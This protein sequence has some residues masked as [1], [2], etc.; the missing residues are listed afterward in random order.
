MIVNVKYLGMLVDQTGKTEEKIVFDNKS[1]ADLDSVLQGK[2]PILKELPYN[3]VVNHE[4][5]SS[6]L[7]LQSTDEIALL[8]P[9][10]GG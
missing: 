10:A 9:F 4:V 7:E 2:Y 5:A 3:L 6:S 8:P 1:L